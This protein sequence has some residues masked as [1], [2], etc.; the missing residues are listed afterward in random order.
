MQLSEFVKI[1]DPEVSG[2]AKSLVSNSG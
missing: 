2:V 1:R